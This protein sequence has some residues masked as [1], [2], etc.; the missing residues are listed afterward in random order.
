MSPIK[1]DKFPFGVVPSEVQIV[2]LPSQIILLKCVETAIFVRCN[3]G[4]IP[5]YCSIK[6]AELVEKESFD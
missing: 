3:G 1:P 6:S 5:L 2:K 4:F